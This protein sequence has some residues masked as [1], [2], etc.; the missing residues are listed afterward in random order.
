[1]EHADKIIRL[2]DAA[3]IKLEG[4]SELDLQSLD[5]KPDEQVKQKEPEISLFAVEVNAQTAKDGSGDKEKSDFKEVSGLSE[6]SGIKEELETKKESEVKEESEAKDEN[7]EKPLIE[8]DVKEEVRT[9][10]EE[11]E[12]P[13]D[14]VGLETSDLKIEKGQPMNSDATNGESKQDEN[15]EEEKMQVEPRPRALHKTSS[16]FLRNLPP[17]VVKSEVEDVSMI[18]KCNSFYRVCIRNAKNSMDL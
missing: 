3:V 8:M 14:Q 9:K 1:M 7:V 6:E 12:E 13:N 15:G 11:E 17:N 18:R 10:T 4:G 2:L 5:E 16:I